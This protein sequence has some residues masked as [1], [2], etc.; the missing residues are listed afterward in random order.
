MAE[1]DEIVKQVEL[2]VEQ[3]LAPAQIVDLSVKEAED[4]DGDPIF[5]ISVVFNAK[6]GRLDP[7]RVLGLIRHLRNKLGSDRFPVLSFMTSEEA[8]DAAA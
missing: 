3:Q 7:E 2:V 1:I 8:A 5:R 4:A 6:E